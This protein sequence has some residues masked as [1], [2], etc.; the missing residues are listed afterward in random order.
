MRDAAGL[1]SPD[2]SS[3]TSLPQDER[4]DRLCNRFEEAWLAGNRPKIEVFVA[5]AP[6]DEWSELLRELLVVELH[7]RRQLG[8]AP[9]LDEYRAAYPALDFAPLSELFAA[10]PSDLSGITK[11]T[12]HTTPRGPQAS[13]GNAPRINRVGD[14]ELLEEIARGGMGVVYKARQVSLGRTVAVKMILAGNLATKADHDRFHQE[15]EAAALLDHPNILPVFEVGEHCGQHYFSMGYVDGQSLAARL[16]EGPLPPREAAELVA[17]VAEA[18]DYAHR[19]GVVHRDIKP[20]NILLDSQGRPRVTDFGLAKRLGA[21]GTPGHESELTTTGQILGTPSYMAPEQAAG[22]VG[23]V[24]PAADVYSLGALLYAALSGRPPFQA[25]TPLETVHQVLQRE[26]VVLRQLNAAVPRD[27][28]TIVLKCLEKPVPRRYATAQ[29]VADDLRRFLAG[30]TIEARP[31]GRW[32]HSWRWCRRQPVVAGLIAAVALTLVAGI[33]ISSLFAANAFR[34]AKIARDN[35][36]KLRIAEAADQRDLAQSLLAQAR[37]SS[38]SRLPGQRFKTLEALCKVRQIEG[39]S[40]KLADE[41]VAALCMADLVPDKQWPGAPQ[42]FYTGAF[43]P[44]LD[45]YAGC[46]MDGNITVRRVESDVEIAAFRTGHRVNAYGGLEFSSDGR[47]LRA[48]TYDAAAGSRLFRVDA[49]AR[50]T[51]GVGRQQGPAATIL[52][53]RHIALAFSPDSRRFIALY[54]GGEYR[55]CELPSGKEIRRYRFPGVTDDRICWNPKKPQLALFHRA[56]WRIVDLEKGELQAEY[57]M[58]GRVGWV[59]W[60]PDGRHLAVAADRPAAIE[61]YDTQTRRMVARQAVGD[62][63]TAGLVPTF[64]HAGELLITNDWSGMRRIWDPACGTDL[65]HMAASSRNFFLVSP[66]D[67]RAAFNVE[68]QD[69]QTMSIAAGAERT[70][71]AAPPGSENPSQ[72]PFAEGGAAN[73]YGAEIVPSPDGRLLAVPSSAGVSLV[74]P[75]TGFELAV[76]PDRGPIRFDSAGALLTWGNYGFRRWPIE[77]KSEGR[78]TVVKAPQSIFDRIKTNSNC[79]ASADGTVIAMAISFTNS[80]TAVLRQA[81]PG[82]EVRQ[83]IAGPQADVRHVAVSPNGKWVAAGCFSPAAEKL[84]NA[85][86]WDASTGTLQATLPVSEG[87]WVWFS[88][89]GTWL[90]TLSRTDAECRLWR[91]GTWHAGP[92]FQGAS[93]IAFSPD[94]RILAVGSRTGQIRLCETATGKEFAIVPAAAGAPAYPRAFSPDGTLLYAKIEWD[95]N[96]HVWDLRQIREGLRELGLDQGWPDFPERPAADRGA[97]EP[98]FVELESTAAR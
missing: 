43:S 6:R 55:L 58:P 11:V 24:G 30:R 61:I 74:D 59:A 23:A 16:A 50:G 31:V 42:G 94:E 69:L 72:P 5:E 81:K 15:A 39:P 92:R 7:Y 29:A 3:Y 84:T 78:V 71:A 37:L 48:T 51:Q 57:P 18:V 90:A 68:G 98:P 21:P 40:R 60:H 1:A 19:Q 75:K 27:L 88:P 54:P 73:D 22:Q 96:V 41:A 32:E 28:E 8:E 4:I 97:T 79:S 52:D 13:T 17:T 62:G 20:S 64:N 25:A 34:Q 76:V 86:V 33:A 65:L 85:K 95:K 56:G 80:G 47:Y 70:F 36:S 67:R 2:D 87:V 66:D 53:D 46:D 38:K 77:H 89:Q 49:G 83:R 10:R 93:E 63:P 9:S 82:R 35:E 12:A 26:P 14:Y 45:V 44:L 91:T